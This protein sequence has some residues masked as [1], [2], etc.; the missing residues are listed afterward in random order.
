MNKKYRVIRIRE[1]LYIEI[2]EYQLELLRQGC[3]HFPSISE[4]LEAMIKDKER[5]SK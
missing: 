4:T 2:K 3:N 1:D 5:R